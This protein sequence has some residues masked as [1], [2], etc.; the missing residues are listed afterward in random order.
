MRT[1]ILSFLAAAF[2][3]TGCSS[4]QQGVCT[5]YDSGGELTE[6]ELYASLFTQWDN[7]DDGRLSED[8]VDEGFDGTPFQAWGR[9]FADWFSENDDDYMSRDEFASGWDSL[10]I[11]NEWDTDGDG[12]LSGIECDNVGNAVVPSQQ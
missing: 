2:F 9:S 5:Q 4:S 12:S 3:L 11:F 8:E 7:D 1:L 10:D 6:T